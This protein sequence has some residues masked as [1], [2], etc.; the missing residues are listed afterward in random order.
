MYVVLGSNP[1]EQKLELLFVTQS[2][3][4]AVNLIRSDDVCI[5]LFFETMTY[6]ELPEIFSKT[7]AA[8]LFA[9]HMKI[10]EQKQFLLEKRSCAAVGT[11]H[12]ILQLA[13]LG[14]AAAST[15]LVLY[16]LVDAIDFSLL[17]VIVV[18]VSVDDK[19][20]SIMDT[21][22]IGKSLAELMTKFCSSYVV[23]GQLKLV[24]FDSN[25]PKIS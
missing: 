24:I 3:I 2:A 11:P 4:R 19:Q 20:R 14:M 1:V 22:D 17:K 8:K 23:A 16:M 7:K 12:R 5:A 25:E 10:E 18:D 13:K 21:S 15:F 6:R 9:K